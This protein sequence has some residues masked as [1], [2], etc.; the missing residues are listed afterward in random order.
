MRLLGQ[1]MTLLSDLVTDLRI[2]CTIL[3]SDRYRL[4]SRLLHTYLL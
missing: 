3:Q 4:R 1:S 2:D